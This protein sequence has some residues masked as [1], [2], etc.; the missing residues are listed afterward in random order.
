M[1]YY[2]RLFKLLTWSWYI[3]Y[4]LAYTNTWELA[5]ELLHKITF[6]YKIFVGCVL[7]WF[8]NPFIKTEFTD[9]H[10]AIVFTAAQFI[11]LS[12]G[13]M[14]ILNNITDDANKAVTV[15]GNTVNKVGATIKTVVS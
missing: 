10:R 13:L 11:L 4:G 9:T 5:P 15:T 6:Y 3:L 7:F 8:F 1:K 12:E 14:N 2:E